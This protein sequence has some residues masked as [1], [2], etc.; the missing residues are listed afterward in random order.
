MQLQQDLCWS[1]RSPEA[2]LCRVEARSRVFAAH[3]GQSEGCTPGAFATLGK[4]A[5]SLEGDS[6]KG[7]SEQPAGHTWT[8][9]LSPEEVIRA[10][11]MASSTVPLSSRVPESS[12]Q[13][14][15]ASGEQCMAHVTPTLKYPGSG[16]MN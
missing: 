2:R 1:P 6:G 5:P 7:L 4:A 15:L 10:C 8:G 12:C 9:C 16:S 13:L 3:I 14:L 11:T